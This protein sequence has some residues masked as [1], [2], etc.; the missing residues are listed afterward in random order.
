MH[1]INFVIK[2]FFTAFLC[3]SMCKKS[4]AESFPKVLSCVKSESNNFDLH[5]VT[6]V[7][8]PIDGR[9]EAY[10]DDKP[11]NLIFDEG[12]WLGTS[13]LGT[14]FL[15]LDNKNIKLI[16]GKNTWE[17]EC[18]PTDEALMPLIETVSK[19][20]S[21]KIETLNKEL[22]KLKSE[23]ALIEVENS[24]LIEKIEDNVTFSDQSGDK[25]EIILKEGSTSQ[26]FVKLLNENP[27]FSGQI[28]N[29]P[30]EGSLAPGK[31]FFKIGEDREKI[32]SKLMLIQRAN[33]GRAWLMR[34]KDIEI[35][36]PRELL[37]LASIVE[38]ETVKD[39]EK[40]L[41]SSVFH[42]R[43]KKK[44]KLQADPTV[45]YALTKG[46]NTLARSPT[47]QELEKK[48]PYNT[49]VVTG[50]PISPISNPSVSSL[51]AAARPSRTDFL[52]FVSNGGGGHSF[53]K[54]YE[55][56]KKGI[57][58]LLTRK[59][60]QSSAEKKGSITYIK[61]PIAKPILLE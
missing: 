49:Y 39:S 37:I 16:S 56:H 58:I 54:T 43:L 7:S 35:S 23:L 10:V 36:N 22:Y 3:F 52:Y 28:E 55:G 44:M 17:G 8:Q 29:V 38:K 47:R 48:S 11:F 14:Q 61:I 57:E 31:Y 13:K 4:F 45:L 32:V 41:I 5:I 9:G 30:D 27:F 6:L 46:R 25:T 20:L 42:N 60:E 19:P 26:A 15:I 12:L 53:S 1:S 50:L 21:L 34:S 51:F 33:I 59:K 2:V 18:F 24:K 40:Q